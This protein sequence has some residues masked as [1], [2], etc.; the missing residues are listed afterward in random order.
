[1]VSSNRSQSPG[2]TPPFILVGLL[3]LVCFLAYNYWSLSSQNSDLV[4]ELTSMQNRARDVSDEN[5]QVKSSLDAIRQELSIAKK[6]LESVKAEV[7]EK[8]IQLDNE[9]QECANKQSELVNCQESL[10]TCAQ[11]LKVE[12]D[13][14]VK[15]QGEK[16]AMQLALD[17]AKNAPK[18]CDMASCEGPV[19]EVVVVAAKLTGSQMIGDALAQAGLDAAKLLEGVIIPPPVPVKAEQPAQSVQNAP[20]PAPV[21][22]G[23]AVQ[24]PAQQDQPAEQ[25]LAVEEGQ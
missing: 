24:A 10:A 19:K 4:V 20:A 2:R 11:S 1:M 18:V 14:K 13:E 17:A 5:T 21:E 25:N 8:T 3:V 12:Q 6:N 15:I 9:K 22:N 7:T 16:D 23:P